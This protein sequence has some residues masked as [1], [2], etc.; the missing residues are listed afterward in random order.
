MN[1]AEKRVAWDLAKNQANKK[2]H[3]VSFEEAATC[4]MID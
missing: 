3:K 1:Q 4:S 2:K